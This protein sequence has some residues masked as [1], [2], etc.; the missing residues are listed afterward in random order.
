MS[1]KSREKGKAGEREAAAL[2]R[3]HGFVLARRGQQHRGGP[4][5]PDCVGL[6]GWHVEVKRTKRPVAIYGPLAQ[7]AGEA[8]AS[9][10]PVVLH[11]ADR[12]GWVAVL[13]AEDF[14]GLAGK[15]E[16]WRE[17][18]RDAKGQAARVIE[19]KDSGE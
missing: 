6:P 4:D 14:L 17:Y 19:S 3:E 5:S 8:A 11:R 13:R 7:A 18:L 15:A 1:K 12:Q 16:C 2:L 10:R 9:E